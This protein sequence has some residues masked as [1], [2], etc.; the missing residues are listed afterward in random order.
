ML[1]SDIYDKLIEI[2]EGRPL[3]HHITNLVVTNITANLTL[4][5]GG[6]PIMANAV[7]E[8]EEMVAHA[9]TLILNIGTLDRSQVEAMLLAGK[10]AKSIGTPVIMDPVGAGAT[11]YRSEISRSII[12]EVEPDIIRGNLAEVLAISGKLANIRGVE[13]LENKRE[14]EIISQ[15]IE[16]AR[17]EK[18]RTIAI[19]GKVDIVMDDERVAKLYNGS[20]YLTKITGSGCMAT[21]AIACF[22]AVEEDS[23]L[24]SIYGLL[25][26]EVSSEIAALRS[27]GPGSFQSELLDSVCNITEKELEGRIRCSIEDHS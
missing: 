8:V 23:F 4:A 25:L 14:D 2:R 22:S 11:R 10:K 18:D 6:L 12:K 5:I 15:T 19:T 13:S 20:E 17:A 27:R 26:Y 9:K 16:L 7:E 21:T 1:A 3:I 24:A